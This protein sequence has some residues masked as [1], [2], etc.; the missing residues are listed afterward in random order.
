MPDTF[1][2][3]VS[4]PDELL[5]LTSDLV[6]K[7]VLGQEESKPILMEFL[8]DILNL[9][10]Q[11]PDQLILQNPNID[12]EHQTDKL[13]TLDIRVQLENRT[14]IDIEVQVIN[15][16][17]IEPRA[18]YYTCC[19]CAEQL[20]KGEDYIL[21]RP[22]IGLNLLLFDLDKKDNYYRSY[23]LKDKITNKEYPPLFEIA[24]LE[25]S[26]GRRLLSG[27]K[28]L[29]LSKK[30]LWILFLTAKNKEVQKRMAEQNTTF[31]AAYDRLVTASS[32]E[33]LRIQ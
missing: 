26:K 4:E 7:Q 11:S 31:Q 33:E 24:F 6:F 21:L 2:K 29:P 5:P 8:N 9:N 18:L 25:L 30:D 32:D 20:Q 13:S 12:R 28:D 19:L 16:H 14:S 15:E 23:V 3:S 10:I 17:N 27:K 1:S 22:S